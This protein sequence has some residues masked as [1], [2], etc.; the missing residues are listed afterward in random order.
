MIDSLLIALGIKKLSVVIA[1]FLGGIVSLRF[2]D[3]LQLYEKC[4]VATTGALAANYLTPGIIAYFDMLASSYEGGIGFMIGLFGMS[5]TS[6]I[7]NILKTTDWAG[8]I[9]GRLGK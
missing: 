2:F 8:I 1:G 4:G 7:F 3:G 6:A 5:V 9:K